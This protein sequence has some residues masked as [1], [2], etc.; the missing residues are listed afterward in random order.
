MPF[1]LTWQM[2]S[3]MNE[4]LIKPELSQSLRAADSL[5]KSAD[6]TSLA[7]EKLPEQFARDREVL[8]TVFE[9]RNG[10]LAKLLGEVRQTTAVAD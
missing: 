7:M 4:M 9:D 6:R 10:R 8:L 1:L 2:E 3:L 5:A